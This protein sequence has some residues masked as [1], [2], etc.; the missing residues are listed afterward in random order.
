MVCAVLSVQGECTCNE[1]M[2]RILNTSNRLDWGEQTAPLLTDYMVRMK[3][4]GYNEKY[5]KQV[6][7]KTFRIHD[8]K[9]KDDSEGIRPINRPKDWQKEERMK[10]KRRKKY[11]W[12]TKGGCIAPIIIPPT[13]NSELLHMLREVAKVEAQ[14]GLKFK[15]VESGD[16]TIKSSV[17]R[18]NPTA[19]P[20]CQG[21]D[22]VACS[23]ERGSGG[24]CR[25]SNVVYQYACQ[26]CPENNQAVYIGETARN[27]YSR[28]RE[29]TRNYEKKESESFMYKHQQEKHHGVHPNF[30]AKILYSFQDSFSRQTA[31][32]VC[33]RRCK[34]DILN[35]KS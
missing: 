33:I 26:L 10:D 15:I 16:R 34:R 21:G 6:L 27:L 8:R 17:Q 4:A 32:G 11:T 19:S 18:S 12:G 29:H 23:G 35:T 14:P 5:R 22:C 30:K 9:M 25:K 28:G 13:P 1:M 2:R 20:G 24:N 31:E 3:E 7:E